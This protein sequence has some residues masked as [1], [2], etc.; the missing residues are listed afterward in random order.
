MVSNVTSSQ[1]DLPDFLRGI[2]IDQTH[3]RAWA[4]RLIGLLKGTE[5]EWVRIHPLP[6][7]ILDASFLEALEKFCA[8]GYNLIIPIDVGVVENVG[9]V[10]LKNLDDFIDNS[11][12]FSKKAVTDISR[13]VNKYG[14]QVIYGV[15][16]EIDAKEW[17]LQSLPVVGWRKSFEAWFKLATDAD[18][19]YKRLNNILRGIKDGHPYAKTM[20]NVE[21]DDIEHFTSDIQSH[22]S[23]SEKVLRDLDIIDRAILNYLETWEVELER[24][25]QRLPVDLVGLDNYPNYLRKHPVRGEEIGSRLDK[26]I[27][28]TG[29]PVINCEF[30]YTAYRPLWQRILYR[31]QGI[32]SPSLLQLQF[33]E[34]ALQSIGKSG[35]RGTFPWVIITEPHMKAN[36]KEEKG[37]GLLKVSAQGELRREP[38]FDMYLNWLKDRASGHSSKAEK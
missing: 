28:I 23:W 8:A 10:T 1:K 6:T 3:V 32:Q 2:N 22:L 9:K 21:A 7:R 38:A 17:F 20:A 26:A 37:F 25:K 29:K 15:E 30:G 31:L 14:R 34:N 13:I 12:E 16:N 19:K 18:L 27:E 35:S 36:P 11:Y 5:I 4:D 24:V 33:F